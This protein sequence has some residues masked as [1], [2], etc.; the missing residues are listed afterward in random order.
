MTAWLNMA[1]QYNVEQCCPLLYLY[2]RYLNTLFAAYYIML[3]MDHLLWFNCVL[4]EW[5]FLFILYFF[6][7]Y[8]SQESNEAQQTPE[9]CQIVRYKTSHNFIICYSVYATHTHIHCEAALWADLCLQKLS[10]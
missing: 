3:K 7:K 10:H 8:L 4:S 5:L 2:A 1:V 9:Q 6:E